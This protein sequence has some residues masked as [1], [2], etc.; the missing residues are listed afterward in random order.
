[1]T[2]MPDL[3]TNPAEKGKMAVPTKYH[4]VVG[5]CRAPDLGGV[6]GGFTKGNSLSDPAAFRRFSPCQPSLPTVRGRQQGDG[7]PPK[8]TLLIPPD[9]VIRN[10]RPEY[11][12]HE[13]LTPRQAFRHGCTRVVALGWGRKTRP[14][15]R[16]QEPA[17]QPSATRERRS[18]TVESAMNFHDN[19]ATL[20]S[21]LA[22]G[23]GF[24]R[25]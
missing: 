9:Q 7:Y 25:W 13:S 14:K 17:W 19:R 11:R 22:G 3:L 21:G 6:E 1:M 16:P 2:D 10:S 4:V 23:L 24:C 15:E 8:A 12:L 5:G 20:N 18:S